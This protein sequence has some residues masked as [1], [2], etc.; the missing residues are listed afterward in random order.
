MRQ[1]NA[2]HVRLRVM[3]L[4][5]VFLL[6]GFF[7]SEVRADRLSLV[8]DTAA[9]VGSTDVPRISINQKRPLAVMLSCEMCDPE[10]PDPGPDPFMGGNL[11]LCT[12]KS[13][14][15]RWPNHVCRTDNTGTYK[16]CKS[17]LDTRSCDLF[18]YSSGLTTCATCVD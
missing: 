11:N 3:A 18:T 12:D 14:G 7:A 13:K 5:G 17:V 6:M 16:Y 10:N 4:L 2:F 9:E 1:R 8:M 15:T